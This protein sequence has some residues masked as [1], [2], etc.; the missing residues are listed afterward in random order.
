MISRHEQTGRLALVLSTA[1]ALA[2]SGCSTADPSDDP[3]AGA[4]ASLDAGSPIAAEAQLHRALDSGTPRGAVAPMMG[5]AALQRGDLAA[6]HEWLDA[7][8][9]SPVTAALG[10]RMRGRLAMAEGDLPLAGQA[11]DRSLAAGGESAPLWADIA[12]L[13]F[14]GG[15]QVQAVEAAQRAVALDA[16]NPEALLLRGQLARDAEGP[17]MAAGWFARALAARPGDAELR[18]EYAATLGDAGDAKGMLAVLR[19]GDDV[20]DSDR[21]LYLQAVLAARAGNFELARDLLE[22]T[23]D[24]ARASPAARLLDAVIDFETGSPASAAQTLGDLARS[25]PDNPH[26]ADM[27]AAA[28]VRSGAAREVVDRFAARAAAPGGSPYLRTLVGRAYETLDERAAAARFLDL[29]TE[30]RIGLV[31]LPDRGG[32]DPALARRDAIRRGVDTATG[33]A[34][35]T[36]LLR[37]HPGSADAATLAGDAALARGEPAVARAHY[38]LAARVRQPWPLIAKRLATARSPAEAVGL[39]E[40]GLRGNPRCGEA[41][42]LLADAYAGRG[43]WRRS[44][45]LLDHALAN[46]MDRVPWVL[47]TRALAAQEMGDRETAVAF[48]L[49]ARDVQPMSV[50]AT[51]ALLAVIP[52]RDSDARSELAQKLASLQRR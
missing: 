37:A 32:D 5:E 44:A 7:H 29:A 36:A 30:P 14:R 45:R 24:D 25:Q 47:A 8:D 11:F 42:A 34:A 31:A 50:V 6:A 9:F 20:A 2:A 39:L 51:T 1:L 48:A 13:R 22:R 15:E 40:A 52:A 16:R 17:A 35:A 43:D 46:G 41:A 4:R 28:L 3:L 21:G 27:W 19:G 18:S 38:A 10:W 49:A 23:G 12:R 26:V 33:V